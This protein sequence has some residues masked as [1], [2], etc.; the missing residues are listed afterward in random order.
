MITAPRVTI[1][2]PVFNGGGYLH[3]TVQSILA[4]DLTD[5]ELIIADN[6]SDDETAAIARAATSDPRVSYVRSPLN[7]GATWNYNRLVAMARGEYFKWAA[8]DDLLGPSFLRSCVEELDHSPAAVL[9]YARTVLI[10]DHGEVIDATFSDGLD[11]RDERP[12]DRFRRYLVHPGEQ[13]AVFG[14]V[15][16]QCSGWSARRTCAARG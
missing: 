6:G 8:H 2:L 15:R 14:V 7:R 1:G 10:D 9:A 12:Q 3:E 11:L 4:Q 13:H 16:M 5:F